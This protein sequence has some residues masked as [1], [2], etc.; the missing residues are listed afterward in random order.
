MQLPQPLQDAAQ[1]ETLAQAG[2]DRLVALQPQ[3]SAKVC[4]VPRG[5]RLDT[6]FATQHL[7][8]LQLLLQARAV[9]LDQGVDEGL[10]LRGV[11]RVLGFKAQLRRVGQAQQP[12]TLMTQPQQRLQHRAIV[13]GVVA[14]QVASQLP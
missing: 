10:D 7:H 11:T 6:Q 8:R 4:H 14:T 5:K 1:G 3:L 2:V 13:Q 12:R 9:L